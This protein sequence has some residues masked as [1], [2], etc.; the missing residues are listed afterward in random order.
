MT[1]QDAHILVA[2]TG[3]GEFPSEGMRESLSFFL[4]REV[5]GVLDIG[6]VYQ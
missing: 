4:K 2:V 3:I 6:K 1:L 5:W